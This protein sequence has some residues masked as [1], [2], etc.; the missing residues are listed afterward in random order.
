VDDEVAHRL[1][2]QPDLALAE[3]AGAIATRMRL[4]TG[5]EPS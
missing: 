1:L 2:E 5:V 3:R 4:P